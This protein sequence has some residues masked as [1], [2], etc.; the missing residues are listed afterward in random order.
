MHD[1]LLSIPW[2]TA[3]HIVQHAV[4]PCGVQQVTDET[5]RLC[6][7][8][9]YRHV[10]IACMQQRFL[11]LKGCHTTDVGHFKSSDQSV[12]SFSVEVELAPEVFLVRH[13]ST[14]LSNR[15]THQPENGKKFTICPKII[16]SKTLYIL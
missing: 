4:V 11:K 16:R 2:Q 12:K 5:I 14:P 9:R 7:A 13:R 15:S 1:V 6:L 8:L 10:L 3:Y